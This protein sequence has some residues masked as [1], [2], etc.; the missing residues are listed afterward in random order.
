VVEF[1]YRVKCGEALLAEGRT[2]HVVIGTDGKP[3]TMP[4]RYLEQLKRK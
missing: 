3:R 2:V 1:T 4:D